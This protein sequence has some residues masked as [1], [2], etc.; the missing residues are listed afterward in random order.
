ML[1]LGVDKWYNMRTMNKKRS[2]MRP[3]RAS[4]RFNFTRDDCQ[5]EARHYLAKMGMTCRPVPCFG[6]GKKSYRLELQGGKDNIVGLSAL[7][8]QIRTAGLNLHVSAV[9]NVLNSIMDILPEYIAATGRSVRIGN[10]VTLKPFATGT[11]DEETDAPDPEK[12]HV[13]IRAVVS[14]ALRYSLAKVRLINSKHKAK[15]AD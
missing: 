10:L 4:G 3:K 6:G 7:S 9:E 14:P 13:E 15:P 2:L 5:L 1:R 12:S 8:E 11:I